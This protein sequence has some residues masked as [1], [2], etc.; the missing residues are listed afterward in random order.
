MQCKKKKNPAGEIYDNNC[1]NMI[2]KENNKQCNMRDL[3]CYYSCPL[4]QQ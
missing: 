3:L 4:T 1:T 2:E